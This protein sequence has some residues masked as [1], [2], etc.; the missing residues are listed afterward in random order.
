MLQSTYLKQ[1]RFQNFTQC[2][3]FF[4]QIL[5][6]SD[7]A[8]YKKQHGYRYLSL[9]QYWKIYIQLKYQMRNN[10]HSL[11]D[12]KYNW[13][14]NHIHISWFPNVPAYPWHHQHLEDRESSG[15][16]LAWRWSWWTEHGTSLLW[17]ICDSTLASAVLVHGQCRCIQ[18]SISTS[19]PPASSGRSRRSVIFHMHLDI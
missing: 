17:N 10:M 8:F 14:K 7:L 18:I 4:W 19:C 16:W 6:S 3:F 5:I 15:I 9:K 1:S 13:H 2:V 12:T 11:F